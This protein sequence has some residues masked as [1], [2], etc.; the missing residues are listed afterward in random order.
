ML[1]IILLTIIYIL[2]VIFGASLIWLIQ[3]MKE[4]E[5]GKK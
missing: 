3:E 1:E 5:N 4:K 2:G